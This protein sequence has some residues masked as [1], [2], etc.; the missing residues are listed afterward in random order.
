M[1]R[2][3]VVVVGLGAM[4]AATLY[5]L[6][7]L[8]VTAIGIDRFAPPHAM[9]S[10]HGETRITRCAVGEG[11][12]YVPFVL[13]SHALWRALEAECGESLLEACGFLMMAPRGVRTG[14]HGKTDFLNKTIG[15]A[16]RH[17]IAHALLDAGEIAARFPSFRLS[18]TEEGYLEPG[19]GFLYPERCVA[20]QLRGAAARGAQV[21]TGTRVTGTAREGAAMRVETTGE[22]V[23]ADQVVITA[24]AWAGRLAGGRAPDVLVPRRQQLHWFP[25]EDEAVHVPGRCPSYVW[26]HGSRPEDYFYGFPALP[27]SGC[28]KVATE[29]YEE[30]CDPDT[31]SRMVPPGASATMFAEHVAGRI[32]GAA[33]APSR[34]AA[35]L[36]TVTPDSGFVI[37]R[38][39]GEDRVILASP[40]SGHGFKHSAAIGEAIAQWAVHGRADLDLSPFGIG[41]YAVPAPG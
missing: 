38:L 19:G 10:S 34:A 2:A 20:A 9:G 12:E 40:C 18:G 22:P 23:L 33:A 30:A 7:R 13:R 5:Y 41:R 24:G 8:G 28:V 6:A 27:G 29:Q 11:A 4:G 32:A 1:K 25:V 17:G 21:M 36:Y 14:H 31:V 16:R 26:M 37:D 15:V 35:C 3:D 39:P